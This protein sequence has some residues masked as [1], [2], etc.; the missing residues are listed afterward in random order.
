MNRNYL[1]RSI[2]LFSVILS[3]GACD[4]LKFGSKSSLNTDDFKRQETLFLGLFTS[5]VNFDWNKPLNFSET[6]IVTNIMDGL[7][8]LQTVNGEV[9]VQPALAQSWEV[10]LDGQRVTFKLRENI[11]WSNGKILKAQ[12]F[13]DGFKRL[14][15]SNNPVTACN[16][17]FTIKNAENFYLRKTTNFS[18]VGITA[19]DDYTLIFNLNHPVPY[20][21]MI[22][23]NPAT[24]PIHREPTKDFSKTVTLGPYKI[25]KLATKYGILVRHD[26]YYGRKPSVKN[27]VFRYGLSAA[28]A[29]RFF[30][31]NQLD[32]IVDIPP[33]QGTKFLNRQELQNATT[34][35]MI[36]LAFDVHQKPVSSP[37]MRRAIGMSIDR[38]EALSSIN[39]FGDVV[40]GMIPPHILGYESNRGVR[41]DPGAAQELLKS[42]GYRN[43]EK[44]KP[45]LFKI[46][47][48][49]EFDALAENIVSQ[50]KRNLEIDIKI[51]K[52]NV[53]GKATVLEGP[54]MYL[55]QWQATVPDPDN[56]MN[57]FKGSSKQNIMGWKNREFDDYVRLASQE[58]NIE[59]RERAYAKALHTLSEEEIPVVPLIMRK[60]YYLVNGRVHGLYSNI[61][62][63]LI[64]KEASLE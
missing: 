39:G 52:E 30:I 29:L 23:A 62:N 19:K 37:I 6:T 28:D 3:L 33:T 14:L 1:I 53:T 9:K 25:V 45:I 31:T 35:N 40:T 57:L 17:L 47:D 13:I 2:I 10:S 20:F 48:S 4:Y 41:F 49:G 44:V 21:P 61:L 27:L 16:F 22:F 32:I 24:F 12:E 60:Q 64:L 11:K 26:K 36:Y 46:G 18:D 38:K 8:K 5:P 51:V 7:T 56:F 63:H 59:K 15:N 54:M 42:S 43:M 55:G 34:L 58:M 50:L